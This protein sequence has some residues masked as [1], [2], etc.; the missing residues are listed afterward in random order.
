MTRKSGFKSH[1]DST[2]GEYRVESV[3]TITLSTQRPID[4]VFTFPASTQGEWCGFGLWWSATRDIHC[5]LLNAPSRRT[6]TNAAA[7]NWNKIGSM[8]IRGDAEPES[9]TARFTTD[10][11]AELAIYEPHCGVIEHDHLSQ[12]RA[13]L[14]RNMAQF[15]PEA[16]F[17]ARPGTVT[18]PEESGRVSIDLP[19][20]SCNRCARFLPINVD[21]EREHL[22]FSN[23]CVS[24]HRRPCKHAGFGRLTH[25]ETGEV[26]SLEYGYQLE[27]RFCKKFEVNAAHNPQRTTAQMKEDGARRR[28][29]E[30][31]VEALK[32]T[33][34]QLEYRH[35]TGRELADDVLERFGDKCFKCNADLSGGRTW[36]LD[37]TRPLALLWPL[38]IS[39]TALCPDCNTAKRDRPP[40][41]FYSSDEITRLAEITGI[42]V[43]ELA[44]PEPNPEV[45]QLLLANLDWFF[46]E[47]LTTEDMTRERDGKTAG[48]LLT[49]ALTK[50]LAL[51]VDGEPLDLVA[52][53]NRRRAGKC[54]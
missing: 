14:L 39:A 35:K 4:I 52:E 43:D 18:V 17:I 53:L 15:S 36:H 11:D 48:E 7:P 10:A 37:H 6:L 13:E 3:P 54:D 5:E 25:V 49:K 50:V 29:I 1:A 51:R 28:A 23:H 47:F 27:C 41:E 44:N 42:S 22:S 8:W 12:A 46:S 34:P 21:N 20:K 33:T 38:D 30:L 24:E 26:L 45:I 16:H 32:K 9:V 40:S 2:G 31:L 19:L